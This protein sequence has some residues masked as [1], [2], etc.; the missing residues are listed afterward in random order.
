MLEFKICK[1]LPHVNWQ[2]R[3]VL[4]KSDD[5]HGSNLHGQRGKHHE[6]TAG[7][8]VRIAKLN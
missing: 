3:G 5:N 1:I 2:S 4:L 7:Y 6:S 8:W